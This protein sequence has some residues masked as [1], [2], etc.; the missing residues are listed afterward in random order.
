MKNKLFGILFLCMAGAIFSGCNTDT[1]TTPKAPD[2]VKAPAAASGAGMTAKIFVLFGNPEP[3]AGVKR[4]DSSVVS[5][6]GKGICQPSAK[7]ITNGILVTFTINDDKPNTLI[8]SFSMTELKANQLIQ[9]DFFKSPA[10]SYQFDASF[11]VNQIFGPASLPGSNKIT[12]TSNSV[13]TLN[14]DI[15]TDTITFEHT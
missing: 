13:L 6:D 8:M 3:H 11:D 7:P 4:S 1:Q 15:M 2:A 10:T 9:F 14:G 12:P 5:C